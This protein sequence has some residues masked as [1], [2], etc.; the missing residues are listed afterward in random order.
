LS[1]FLAIDVDTGGVFV[2]AGSVRKGTVALSHAVALPD[3]AGPLTAESAPALG[4]KL[5]DLLK[6]AGV[7]AAPVLFLVG[8][9][10]VLL[11]DVKHPPVAGAE[12]PAVVRFQANKELN[13]S[14]DDFVLDY[15][16]VGLQPDGS[17]KSLAAFVKKDVVATAKALCEAA[18]LKLAAIT[19]RAFA[20][21]AGLRA[22][23]AAGT[24][25]PDTPTDAVALIYPTAA[26]AEFAVVRGDELLFS[27]PIPAAALAT[28]SAYLA[29]ARR[30]LAVVNGQVPGGVTALYLAE[31]DAPGG[32]W[33]GRLRASL[34]IPVRPYDP[35]A[36][37][38]AADA[39]PAQ[40]RGAFAAAVGALRLRALPGPLPIN[41]VT[42]RQPKAEPNKNRSKFLAA[43]LAACLLL[44]AGFLGGLWLDSQKAKELADLEAKKQ[45]TD[46]E[47]YQLMVNARRGEAAEEF[48]RHQVRL[49]DELYD[50]TDLFPEINKSRVTAID[51]NANALPNKGERQKEEKAKEANPAYKPLV[52]PVGTATF[53]VQTSDRN[54]VDAFVKNLAGQRHY[55]GVTGQGG[56]ITGGAA[57]AAGNQTFTVKAGIHARKPDQYTRKLNVTLPKPKPKASEFDDDFGGGGTGFPGF[58]ALPGGATP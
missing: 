4:R 36:G 48:L 12:E 13:D 33:A 23:F 1:Q 55:V 9:D 18:G 17:R 40:Y 29:E 44:G 35:L 19:P 26:A 14:P 2:T 15:L 16:P 39:V 42:P 47:L 41:F 50:W 27:R 46:D 49:H 34:A 6:Q 31:A 3:D 43:A 52:K 8:R 22:A 28:E 57:A 30:N 11:K 10:K 54:V 58:N 7:P 37:S 5:K 24:E 56:A 45:T 53:T 38:P 32:G 20:A 21:A 51:F 25:P